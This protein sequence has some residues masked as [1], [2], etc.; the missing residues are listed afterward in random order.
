MDAT[1]TINP[2]FLPTL[3]EAIDG[4]LGNAVNELADIC[5][6]EMSGSYPPASSPGEPPHMRT[7]GAREAIFC[8][9]VDDMEWVYGYRMVMADPD[10]PN[11]NRERLGLW[12]ELGT[13]VYRSHPDGKGGISPAASPVVRTSVEPRPVLLPT[14][15][16]SGPD[17]LASHLG[18]IL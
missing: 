16:N 6:S 13:G 18:G 17:V 4:A 11:A 7:G 5:R 15:L 9:R 10:R 1:V 2:G 12:L 8:S 3:V 14:L